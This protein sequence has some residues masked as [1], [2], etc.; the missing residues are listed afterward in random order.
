MLNGIVHADYN[1]SGGVRVEL[2]R[3]RLTVRNPGTFRIPVGLVESD[4]HSDPRNSNVMRMFMLVGLAERA[5]SGVH[6]MVTTYR[7]LGLGEPEISESV[8]PSTVTVSM[9]TSAPNP[10]G[11]VAGK[12]TYPHCPGRD[13]GEVRRHP[14]GAGGDDGAVH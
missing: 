5:G 2:R 10:A 8:D 3:D 9:R 14:G 4:G 6:R 1:G 13:G 12:G 7:E 11:P